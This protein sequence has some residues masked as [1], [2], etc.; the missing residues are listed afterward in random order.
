MVSPNHFR[1]FSK[2]NQNKDGLYKTVSVVLFKT[3]KTKTRVINTFIK[4][5]NTQKL[6][7]CDT[8]MPGGDSS[9]QPDMCEHLICSPEKNYG[10]S[11]LPVF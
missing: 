5:Q 10:C 3:F 9:R 7:K 4:P 1:I 11:V 6:K 8:N 2:L